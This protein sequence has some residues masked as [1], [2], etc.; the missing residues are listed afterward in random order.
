ML[1]QSVLQMDI[2]TLKYPTGK[3]KRPKTFKPIDIALSIKTIQEF[4]KKIIEATKDLDKTSLEYLHRPGGW[5]V[6]QLVHHCADSHLNAFIRVKLALTED[7]PVVKPYIEN[8][9]VKL[10]DTAKAP[11]E[12]SLQIIEGMH[13]R[14]AMLLSKMK[15]ADFKRTYYHPEQ[16]RLV[17]MEEVISIYAWHCL[18]HLAHIK[19]ALKHKNKF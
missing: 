16:K 15:G 14:W 3:Y 18:H 17:A 9:W 6:R 1:I 10:E 11:I 2:E 8:E 5:T 7:K 4:P 13:K 12:W 19:Q